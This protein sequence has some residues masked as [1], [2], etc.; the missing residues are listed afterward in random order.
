MAKSTQRKLLPAVDLGGS[1]IIAALVSPQGE[2]IDREYTATLAEEGAEAVIRRIVSAID[3]IIAKANLTRSYFS[4]IVIAAAGAIDVEKGL[5]TASPNLPGWYNI[6][7]KDIMQEETGLEVTLINDASAAALG[8][9]RFGAGRGT[10]NMVYITVSTG[11]GGGIIIDGKLY[12]GASGCAGEIGH[13]TIEPNGPRCNCGNRGCL[14][15]LASGKAVARE[16]QRRLAQGAK[17][18]ILEIAEGELENI[19]SRTVSMAARRGDALA[20]EIISRAA[21]YLGI[22]LANLVNI[23]NPEVVVVGGGMAQVG[24]MF[25]EP[26][27]KV[28]GERAFPLPAQAVRIVRSELGDNAGVVGGAA[29]LADLFPSLF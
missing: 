1:K 2:V 11:I 15:V 23:F 27:R 8:E 14:E 6:P 3:N 16:A 17:S 4:T 13:I 18:I 20:L 26:A 28:V 9:H 25:L 21:Y 29:Y 7:L 5:I 10:N 22:G 19:T 24:N 12:L